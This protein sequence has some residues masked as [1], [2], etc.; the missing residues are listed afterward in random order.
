LLTPQLV[1]DLLGETRAREEFVQ[2]RGWNLVAEFESASQREILG[3]QERGANFSAA[4]PLRVLRDCLH[5]VRAGVGAEHGVDDEGFGEA[6][7]LKRCVHDSRLISHGLR[8]FDFAAFHFGSLDFA[9][10]I[11]YI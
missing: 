10:P 9:I 11:V 8:V 4:R 6:R 5:Q 7:I 3:S 1:F 2:Q